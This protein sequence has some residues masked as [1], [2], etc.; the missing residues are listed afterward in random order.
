MSSKVIHA[1]SVGM[2]AANHILKAARNIMKF[3]SEGSGF[4]RVMKNVRKFR[5][6]PF[7]LEYRS[8]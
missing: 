8:D 7:L 6:L 1:E 4:D 3:M 5:H 2:M